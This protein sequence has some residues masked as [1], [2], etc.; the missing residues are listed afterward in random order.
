MKFLLV[1]T[2]CLTIPSCIQAAW[3]LDWEDDFNGGNLADRWNFDQGCGWFN[4]EMQCY[5]NNRGEN[6]RQENGAL[7]IE[8]RKEWWGDGA[9]P[10]KPFT[11]ARINSKESFHYGKFEMRARLP[12]GKH[13]WPAFWMMPTWSDYGGWP[14]SGEIDIME[15][16][17]QRPQQTLGTLHFGP[18]PDNKGMAGTGERDFPFDFSADWHTFAIDWSP[19]H[20]QWFVD[21][22]VYHT[23][24]LQRNFWPGFYQN[25]VSPFDRPFFIIINLAVGGDFFNGEPF[26]PE[27]ANGWAKN[28]FEI[29]WIRKF[30]WI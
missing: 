19:D 6:A 8:A 25:N 10:D 5:T 13:L 4:N 2:A 7:V 15:Y 22:Q 12:K 11:S 3:Q 16:R 14:R 20:M 9:N 27:E 24:S 23:E 26:D 29:D 17:G 21:D 28:T 1:L 18:S 30:S